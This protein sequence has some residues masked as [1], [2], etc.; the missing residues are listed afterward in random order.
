MIAI[1]IG[2]EYVC[3][4]YSE[5]IVVKDFR[6]LAEDLFQLLTREISGGVKQTELQSSHYAFAGSAN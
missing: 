4:I 2:A 3:E 5:A 6:Q 1:G